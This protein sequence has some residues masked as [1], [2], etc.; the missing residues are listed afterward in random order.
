[1][2]DFS[3][4]IT[5]VQKDAPS[6]NHLVK[7]YCFSSQAIT[8]KSRRRNIVVAQVQGFLGMVVDQGGGR[9]FGH[10]SCF[11]PCGAV[12]GRCEPILRHIEVGT[13]RVWY[14][15]CFPIFAPGMGVVE[16]A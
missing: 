9:V 1:M 4:N 2:R 14:N 8:K 5:L 10:F 7:C 3:E 6:S 15:H 16:K 13:S 12:S 11:L